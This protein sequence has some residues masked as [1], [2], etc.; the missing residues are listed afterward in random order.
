M[1]PLIDLATRHD[2]PDDT[3]CLVR[4]RHSHHAHGL[5]RQQGEQMRISQLRFALCVSHNGRHANDKPQR[6][7]LVQE[8]VSYADLNLRFKE[9]QQVL[10]SR[11]KGASTRVCN[12]LYDGNRFGEFASRCPQVVYRNAR[13]QINLAIANARNGKQVAMSFVIA[14]SR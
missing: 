3:R 2:R 4:Q 1:T 8:R 14:P 7:G 5:A 11:V 12:I 10:I 6:D 13:P 9:N